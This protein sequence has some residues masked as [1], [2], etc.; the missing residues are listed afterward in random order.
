MVTWAR[1][2]DWAR[3][4]LAA[5]SALATEFVGHLGDV[6]R[7]GRG[8]GSHLLG[9]EPQPVLDDQHDPEQQRRHDHRELG[10]GEPRLA[11]AAPHDDAG[12]LGSGML[13]ALFLAAV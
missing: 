2:P 10:G 1:L 11:P 9:V 7:L 5:C 3:K 6:D 12:A 13:L 4:D 8:R